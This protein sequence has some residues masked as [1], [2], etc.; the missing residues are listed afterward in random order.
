MMNASVQ[1]KARYVTDPWLVGVSVTLLAIG[2]VML[3]SASLAV[4]QQSHQDPFHYVVRQSIYVL[5]GVCAALFV[6]RVKMN[7]W[8][9][10]ANPLLA[11]S[12]TLL[13]SVLIPGIGKEVN[14]SYR[15]IDL[16]AFNLQVSE[17]V[18]LFVIIYFAGFLAKKWHDVNAS[19][20]NLIKSLA[21]LI[22]IGVLLL[23]EPDL[24]ASAVIAGT[25]IGMFFLAGVRISYF[26]MFFAAA[27][28]G[29]TGLIVS[30]SY[31]LERLTTFMQ[32]CEPDYHL[33]QGYQLCQALIAF[34]RGEW[35]GVGLGSGVQKEFYLP[36]AHT[37][38]LLAVLGEELGAVG[39]L[40]VIGLFALLFYRAFHIAKQAEQKQQ[41]FSSL[42]G[43]GI[44]LW[45]GLQSLVNMG[46][47]MG[48]LPTKGITL[49]LVSYGGSSI[50]VTC[51]AIAMLIRIAYETGEVAWKARAS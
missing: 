41:I 5:I 38:F 26:V 33:N 20:S 40:L 17:L 49:P 15:W 1:A 8:E 24:G 35:L 13:I 46:V 22:L 2:V 36:E 23:L 32:A 18:K 42:T 25:V 6:V 9:R 28:A 47:N 51:I 11:V 14:G 29:F 50:V 31:R 19:L 7:V 21:P 44:A 45:L 34:G 48:V 3:A 12:V 27:L 4:A 37:D 39:T 43:F 30:A 16:G 10:L